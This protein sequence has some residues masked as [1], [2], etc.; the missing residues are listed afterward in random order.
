M[1]HLPHAPAVETAE[2][3]QDLSNLRFTD[4]IPAC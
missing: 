4:R 2:L 3:P 1:N